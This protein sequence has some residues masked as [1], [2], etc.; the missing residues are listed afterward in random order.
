M[1]WEKTVLTEYERSS[2]SGSA[3]NQVNLNSRIST[4][5]LGQWLE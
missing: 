4:A 3:T 5:I 2:E 1:A